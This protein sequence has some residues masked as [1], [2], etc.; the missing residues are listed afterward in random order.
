MPNFGSG[1]ACIS[2]MA[3][4]GAAAPALGQTIAAV[5]DQTSRIRLSNR[6]GKHGVCVGGDIDD[7]KF[8]AEKGLAVEK[9]G[10]DA[11]INFLVRE[12]DD[13]GQVTRTWVTQP[14]EFFVTCNGAVYPLYAEPSEVPAQTVILSP[15]ARQHARSNADLL[16]PLVEEERAVSITLALLDDRVPASFTD[17]APQAGTIRLANVPAAILIEQRRLAIEGSGLTASEYRVRAA[18]A[19]S[20]DERAFLDPVLGTGLF[21]LTFDRNHLDAGETARLVVIR[22]DDAQ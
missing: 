19:A 8:S 10:S 2:L 7:V 6:D 1:R 3:L 17:V 21:S 4:L 16:G 14:A 11:W 5:P 22:R 20:L 13:A 18:A 9:G 12:S 15:G